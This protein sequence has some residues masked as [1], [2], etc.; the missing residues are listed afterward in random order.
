[1][2]AETALKMAKNAILDP[3]K[4]KLPSRS[5]L[6]TKVIPNMKGIFAGDNKIKSNIQDF[7][8]FLTVKSRKTVRNEHLPEIDKSRLTPTSM[9]PKT[10]TSSAFNRR[11]VSIPP[12]TACSPSE[13]QVLQSG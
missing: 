8:E 9:Y 3:H 5:P 1:M 6:R 4:K 7:D 2:D 10:T 12:K 13:A 11:A